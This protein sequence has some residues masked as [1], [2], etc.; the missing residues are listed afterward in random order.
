[1]FMKNRREKHRFV[2]ILVVFFLAVAFS[3]AYSSNGITVNHLY[4]LANFSG[5]VPY[6]EATISV[7]RYHDEVYVLFQNFVRIYNSAGMEV[8]GFGN[9]P[10]LGWMR[11]LAVDEKGDIYLLSY[12]DRVEGT[13]RPSYHIVRCN[14]R[15][16][17]RG[18][19]TVQGLPPEFSHILPQRL[20]YREGR[21][22]LVSRNQLMAVETDREG[23][24]R[25]GYDFADLLE[26]PEKDRR[27]IEI[28]GFSVDAQGNMLFTI[29]VFFQ[30]Y[31]VSPDGEVSAFGK[32]GSAPGLFG[33]V[34]GIVSDDQGNTL[35]ADSQRSVVMIFD[36][37][38]RFIKEFG[39]YGS[40]PQN[41]VRPRDIALGKSGKLYVVQLGHRG[42]SVFSVKSD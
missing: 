21:F 32:G 13:D 23:T 34:S 11:D 3:P 20:Y 24:F 37:E 41:L 18:T 1:M 31:R 22:F 5:T 7:D 10:A 15:G 35:V 6:N 26:I 29:P 2:I 42:V 39:Y 38:F 25:R 4:T 12:G 33:V 27:N 16:E 8:Y 40:K 17:A 19:I 9:D 30:A 14:Y 36:P 28:F